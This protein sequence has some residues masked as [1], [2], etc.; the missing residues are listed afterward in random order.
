MR[1][2]LIGPQPGDWV[3]LL[4][5]LCRYLL[6]YFSIASGIDVKGKQDTGLAK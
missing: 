5:Q 3:K 6:Y 2:E 4:L 1:A